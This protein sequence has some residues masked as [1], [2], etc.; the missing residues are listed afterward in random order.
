MMVVDSGLIRHYQPSHD[1]LHRVISEI[2]RSLNSQV[3]YDGSNQGP[4]V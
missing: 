1:G 2:T 3:M 4:V